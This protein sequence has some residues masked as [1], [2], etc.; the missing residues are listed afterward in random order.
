MLDQVEAKLLDENALMV[1]INLQFDAIVTCLARPRLIP[2]W[3]RKFNDH[4]CY[5]VATMHKVANLAEYGNLE[6]DDHGNRTNYGMDD[7]AQWYELGE[8]EKGGV[9]T[10]FN[11]VDN[12]PID[13]WP[14]GFYEYALKDGEMTARL[15]TAAFSRLKRLGMEKALEWFIPERAAKHFGLGWMTYYGARVDPQHVAAMDEYIQGE[16]DIRNYPILQEW[17][18]LVPDEPPR[19]HAGGHR[20]HV[21]GCSKKNC[22]CPVKMVPGKKG[23]QKDKATRLMIL[24]EARRLGLSVPL[25]KTGITQH[26]DLMGETKRVL[27]ASSELFDEHLNWVGTDKKAYMPMLGQSEVIDEYARRARTRK[28]Q[29]DYI[30]RFY[31]WYDAEG[32]WHAKKEAKRGQ[33]V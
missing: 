22:D 1:G 9:R 21:E 10:H 31:G 14:P 7:M 26:R 25:T 32:V 8:V 12:I 19:P 27:P 33:E 24:T 5:D 4:K 13:H 15:F 29:T 28:L 16:C 30:H 23:G 11:V 20:D 18:V 17:G 3:F 2:L 6:Y